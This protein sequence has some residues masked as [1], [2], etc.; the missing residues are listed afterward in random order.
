M[1]RASDSESDS[2]DEGSYGS[3]GSGSEG[4][5]SGSGSDNDSESDDEDILDEITGVESNTNDANIKKRK[6]EDDDE[7]EVKFV[8]DDLDGI[9]SSNIIP[10]GK[11]RSALNSGLIVAKPPPKASIAP[12]AAPIAKPPVNFKAK[13]IQDD[14]DEAE[15]EF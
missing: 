10:R 15:A 6:A 7:D 13:S 2:E 5:G 1:A 3:E 4:T 9:D 11:R 8:P 12:S 14:D